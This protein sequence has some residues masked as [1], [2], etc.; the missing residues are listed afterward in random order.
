MESINIL[1]S[2]IML[3]DFEEMV[4]QDLGREIEINVD[5]LFQA[6][7]TAANQ[8]AIMPDICRYQTK[9]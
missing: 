9:S 3:L 6:W 1:I 7:N 2:A 4:R 5:E 8:K